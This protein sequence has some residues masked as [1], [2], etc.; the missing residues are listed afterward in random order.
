MHR[1]LHLLLIALIA[2]SLT[3]C[4]TPSRFPVLNFTTHNATST[5]LNWV[6]INWGEWQIS[7]GVLSAGIFAS[8][9][10]PVRREPPHSDSASLTFIEDSSRQRHNIPLN[11]SEVRQLRDGIYMVTFRITSLTNAD[12]VI[13]PEKR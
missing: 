4:S 8:Q 6:T 9:Y 11:V 3:S 5:D 7:S 12:V 10:Y 13:K 2:F 1:H